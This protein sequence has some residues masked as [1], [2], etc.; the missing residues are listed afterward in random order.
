MRDD[1]PALGPLAKVLGQHLGHVLVGQSMETIAPYALR[2][3]RSRQREVLRE[4][5]LGA[6]EGGIEAR[7]LGHV[8]QARGQRLDARDIV[9][10]MQGRK[11]DQ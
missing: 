9:R 3:E 4:R 7:H 8:V 2:R 5:R 1:H 6:M 11:R 10:L